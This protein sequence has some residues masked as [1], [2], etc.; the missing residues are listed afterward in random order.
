MN[1]NLIIGLA[2]TA[3][4]LNLV[5]FFTDTDGTESIYASALVFVAADAGSRTLIIRGEF[6][7]RDPVTGLPVSARRSQLA[8]VG[9]K[10]RQLVTPNSVAPEALVISAV[11]PNVNRLDAQNRQVPTN[12]LTLEEPLAREV[13]AGA[14]LITH[15][16]VE[17]E[18]LKTP[19]SMQ[20]AGNFITRIPTFVADRVGGASKVWGR[21]TKLGTLDYAILRTD[22]QVITYLRWVLAAVSWGAY[23]IIGL[24]IGRLVRGLL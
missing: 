23:V 17:F 12:A 16:W 14:A 5:M 3:A 2:M 9:A 8:R 4:L 11:G 1:N 7:A 15:E 22:V 13:P 18:D 10:A 21:L 19:Q 20:P 6:D 24:Y